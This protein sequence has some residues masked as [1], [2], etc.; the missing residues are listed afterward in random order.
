MSRKKKYFLN[1]VHKYPINFFQKIEK[2]ELLSFPFLNFCRIF[3]AIC[4]K[5]PKKAKKFQRMTWYNTPTLCYKC[6]TPIKMENYSCLKWQ[7]KYYL[8]IYI[9]AIPVVELS[10]LHS[11]T[12]P[13]QGR[14]YYTGKTLFSL[15][16]A[17]VLIAGTLYSSQGIM[18]SLQ[19]I[20]CENYYTGKSL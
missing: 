4:W 7:S 12:G 17:P 20:P 18:Y 10:T 16:G 14:I 6:L 8:F 2:S 13:V 19:G 9:M 3:Y 1:F 15:Q 5:R 11:L